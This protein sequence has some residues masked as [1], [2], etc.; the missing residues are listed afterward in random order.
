MKKPFA[1]IT[2]PSTEAAKTAER[3]S[4]M[5]VDSF[6]EPLLNIEFL[7]NAEK[8]FS[9]L[10][11]GKPQAVI[12]TSGNGILA[13]NKFNCPKEISLYTVGSDS[14]EIAKSCGFTN[15]T[16]ASGGVDSLI[17]LISK[18]IKP[19]SG[20]LIY[21]SAET[22]S[23]DLPGAL[24]EN[25]FEV[26]N[27]V[28]YKANPVPAFSQ[29]CLNHIKYKVFDCVLFFSKRTT[30]TFLDLIDK[31][32]LSELVKDLRYICLSENV[33][34]PLKKRSFNN[35]MIAKNADS[36]SLLELINNFEFTK[37]R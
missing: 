28:A 22:T 4:F 29:E 2:R 10:M 18:K 33:S 8:I 30:E 17:Q 3:L 36:D 7:T 27:I 6:I 32:N 19:L 35:I 11:R 26:H 25:G 9:P 24:Q 16:S 13:L 37:D 15:I 5:G 1:L 12:T 20:Y 21:I 23:K 31:N 34:E 14:T